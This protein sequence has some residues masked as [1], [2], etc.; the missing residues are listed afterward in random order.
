MSFQTLTFQSIIAQFT[1]RTQ[2]E[3]FLKHCDSEYD[4]KVY[5]VNTMTRQQATSYYDELRDKYNVI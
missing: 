3:Q 5:R 2:Y 1:S 4:L